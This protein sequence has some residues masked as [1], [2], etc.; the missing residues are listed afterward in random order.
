MKKLILLIFFLI[1]SFMIPAQATELHDTARPGYIYEKGQIYTNFGFIYLDG[2]NNNSMSIP[3]PWPT[4][5]IGYG[6][7][8][9]VLLVAEPLIF[10]YQDSNRN[11]VIILSSILQVEYHLP[12]LGIFGIYGGAGANLNGLPAATGSMFEYEAGIEF[13]KYLRIGYKNIGN[14]GTGILIESGIFF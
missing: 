4:A 12:L 9:N 3:I 1:L 14:A 13:S 5:H 8:D 7:S 11:G 6:I 10:G 2:L